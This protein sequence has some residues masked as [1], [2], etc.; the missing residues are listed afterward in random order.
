MLGCIRISTL[1]TNWNKF[2]SALVSSEKPSSSTSGGAILGNFSRKK[3][4]DPEEEE[5]EEKEEMKSELERYREEWDAARELTP[6]ELKTLRK[7]PT[8]TAED[9]R[10]L[11]KTTC[12]L[13]YPGPTYTPEAQ[14]HFFCLRK[15]PYTKSKLKR[16][17]WLKHSKTS[18]DIRR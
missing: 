6:E 17:K 10:N 18:D 2:G 4:A 8:H 3:K 12:C 14:F 1:T 7:K 11:E 15:D 5:K 9:Q 13:E 16:K